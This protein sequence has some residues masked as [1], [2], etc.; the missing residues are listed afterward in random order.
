MIHNHSF[1]AEILENIKDKYD[2]TNYRPR[3]LSK[4]YGETLYRVK[5]ERI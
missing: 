2:V 1:F 4:K 5:I 3:R